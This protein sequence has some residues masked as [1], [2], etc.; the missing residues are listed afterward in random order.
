MIVVYDTKKHRTIRAQDKDGRWWCV[1]G[2]CLRCGGCGCIK[3]KCIHFTREKL[4]GVMKGKCLRQFEKP[5]MCAMYPYDPASP[6]PEG[7]GLRWIKE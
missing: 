2:D 6:L 3:S 1:E 7:C 4:D 5:V